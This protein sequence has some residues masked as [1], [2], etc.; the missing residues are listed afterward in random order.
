MDQAP[1][2][3]FNQGVPARARLAFFALLAVAL[4]IVDARVRALDTM[5]VGVGVLLYPLQQAALLPVAAGRW[6]GDTFASATALA[7]ENEALRRAAAEQAQVVQEARFLKTENEQLRR[8][9]GARERVGVPAVLA[10]LR[11]EA[12]DRFSRKVV[13]DRGAN[14][15]LRAGQPAIDERGV[16]GQVTRTGPLTAEI[17]LLTDKDQSIPVQIVR[18][19][20]RGVAFG[21]ADPGTLELRFMAANADIV[22]GDEAVTSGLDGIYPAGL[23][24]ARVE[25]VEPASKEQFARV[26]MRPAAGVDASALL[27]VLLVE[28]AKVAPPADDGPRGRETRRGARKP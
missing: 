18:N 15:G 14:D 19:G 5:R 3:L 25:R 21:G 12:A 9:L 10:Q 17:T 8:L 13:I 4:M 27:L 20:L 6:V 1:P 2:P 7:R 11:Y 24:V 22:A 28:P 16:V 23:A 26:V